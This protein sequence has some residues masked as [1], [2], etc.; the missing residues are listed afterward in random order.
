MGFHISWLAVRGKSPIAVRATLGLVVGSSRDGSR[1]SAV[2]ALDLPSGWYLVGFNSTAPDEMSE[3]LLARLSRS[4][5]VVT[6]VVEEG[7]MYSIASGYRDGARTWSV[8]HN[9][10][11][12]M[13]H[14]E[15][16]GDLP[17]AYGE[18]RDRLMAEL[19]ADPDP[20][21]YIFDVPVELARSLTGYRHDAIREDESSNP[22]VS[23]SRAAK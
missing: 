20:C 12:G 22:F 18:I 21:D 6:C 17:A 9:A 11:E 14:L 16:E 7:A 2:A 19:E 13:E 10:D 23:L 5:E 3:E 4:A 8:L 15:E 1:D